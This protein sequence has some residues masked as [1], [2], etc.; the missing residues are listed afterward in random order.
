MTGSPDGYTLVAAFTRLVR[1]PRVQPA[2]AQPRRAIGPGW[3]RRRS[4][5]HTHFCLPT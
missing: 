4:H 1:R 3:R 2:Q 5:M